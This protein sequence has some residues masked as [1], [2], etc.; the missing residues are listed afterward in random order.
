MDSVA[1]NC[2]RNPVM[3]TSTRRDCCVPQQRIVAV[4][5]VRHQPG[6]EVKGGRSPDVANLT[7]SYDTHC[8]S[9]PSLGR[10]ASPEKSIEVALGPFQNS[11]VPFTSKPSS[12]I[13][14]SA[15]DCPVLTFSTP[16]RVIEVFFLTCTTRN[17]SSL[18]SFER[19]PETYCRTLYRQQSKVS[20][21]GFCPRYFTV[22]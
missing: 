19:V 13:G 3:C 5:H 20:F 9:Y 10:R 16:H 2:G 14:I 18:W 8:Y 1:Y 12:E 7:I 17:A 21:T 22:V 15:R 11:Q 6:Y 4:P